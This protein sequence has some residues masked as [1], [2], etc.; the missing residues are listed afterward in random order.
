MKIYKMGF[1]I[2]PGRNRLED[3]IEKEVILLTDHHAAVREKDDYNRKLLDENIDYQNENA[4]Q[5]R[6]IA[7]L[8]AEKRKE[9]QHGSE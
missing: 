6:K 4:A 8:I 3:T 2:A 7:D 5:R 9:A 1:K